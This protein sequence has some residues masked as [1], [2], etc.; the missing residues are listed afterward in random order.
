MTHRPML[1]REQATFCPRPVFSLAHNAVI[2]PARSM[3]ELVWSPKPERRLTGSLPGLLKRD[4][5]PDRVQK[6]V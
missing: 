4:I 6:A 2:T 5:A 3:G 1:S